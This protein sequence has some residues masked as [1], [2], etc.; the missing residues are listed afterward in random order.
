MKFRTWLPSVKRSWMSRALKKRFWRGS[1]STCRRDERGQAAIFYKRSC[2]ACAVARQ[3]HRQ[4]R[5]PRW[6]RAPRLTP[7]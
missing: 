3:T 5:A 2:K 7:S 6:A 4:P 1:R